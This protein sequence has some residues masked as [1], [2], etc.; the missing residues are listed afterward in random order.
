MKHKFSLIFASLLIIIL[1]MLTPIQPVQAQMNVV[2]V[3]TTIQA[4]VDAAN[5]GDTVRV[6]PGVYHENVLVMKDN[7][8]IKGSR[9]A[10]LDGTG[11]PGNSGITVRAPSTARI[12]GFS[13]SGLRIQNYSRNGVLLVQV[14]NYQIVGGKYI[15]NDEYGIFPIRSTHG[16][17]ESN[18]VSGSDDTGIYIGQSDGAEIRNNQVSDC[19]VGIEVEVSSNISIQDNKLMDN[20][21]GISAFVLPGLSLT[22]TTNIQVTHNLVIHNN[23]PNPVS[24]PTDI[25]SQLPSGAG[26]LL[27]GVDHAI[28]TANKVLANNSVGIAVF[29]VPPALAALDPRIDP[30]PD[31][32]QLNGNVVLSNGSNPDPKIAPFPPSDLIWDFSGAGNCWSN[33]VYK[34][35]FPAPL[36]ACP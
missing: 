14:D 18:Q 35:S 33:N 12:N 10:I 1:S 6:P 16:L 11:L 34:T 21:I 13:L 17:I 5:P 28:V 4:A 26:L 29:Q 32:D 22:E 23:R 27:I 2:V 7:I 24:D 31:H 3:T 9:G 19:T 25:L 20:T 15:D 8:T 36:P 30:F